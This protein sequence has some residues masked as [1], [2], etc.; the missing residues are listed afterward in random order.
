VT[1]FISILKQ[2]IRD[3]Y[4]QEWHDDIHDMSK[5]SVYC[6]FKSSF[7]CEKYISVLNVMKFRRL[8]ARF[9]CSNHSLEIEEG[10]KNGLLLEHR[11]CKFC[12]VKGVT[13]IEDEYHFLLKCSAYDEFR[14]KYRH[15]A[16]IKNATYDDFINVM[17][18]DD[19]IIVRDTATYLYNAFVY[20]KN[21][22]CNA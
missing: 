1:T 4:Y 12:D 18:S 19:E 20:R 11:I 6:T 17:A 10:R 3:C 16:C 15:L 7:V 5:M 14:K 13:V 2:R 8:Y 9:R 22:I 21:N